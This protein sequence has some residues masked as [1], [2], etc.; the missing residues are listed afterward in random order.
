M[1][2]VKYAEKWINDGIEWKYEGWGDCLGWLKLDK[3]DAEVGKEG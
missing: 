1:L 2:L 3:E